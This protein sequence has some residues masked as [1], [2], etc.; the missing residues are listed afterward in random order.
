MF[1][2][3]LIFDP[4]TRRCDCALGDDGDL[5]IDETSVT[6]M[7][8]SIGLDRRADPDDDLPQ[9]VSSFLTPSSFTERRGSPCDALDADG[10]LAGSRCWLLDRAKQ[11]ETTRRL[12][13]F[14]LA[15]SL[16]WADREL[17][18][19]AEIAVWWARPQTLAWRVRIDA[20]EIEAAQSLGASS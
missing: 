11:T 1:D 6:P 12:Y 9:G 17:G 5:L 14:W 2:A 19:P 20:E 7:L 4:A 3:A 13:A 18:A 15:E 8:M 10:D 16:S